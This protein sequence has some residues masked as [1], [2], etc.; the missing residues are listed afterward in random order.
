[1]PVYLGV[2]VVILSSDRQQYTDTYTILTSYYP[3]LVSLALS[4]SVGQN[5][6]IRSSNEC[7]VVVYAHSVD[8]LLFHVEESSLY[9]T[10]NL[11][12]QACK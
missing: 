9:I 2:D 12:L 10:T 1:M 3:F 7:P 8:Q 11:Q 6:F 4:R 5:V